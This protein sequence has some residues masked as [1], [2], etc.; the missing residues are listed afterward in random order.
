MDIY[1]YGESINF[2]AD[3]YDCHTGNIFKLQEFKYKVKDDPTARIRV[4]DAEGN[5]IGYANRKGE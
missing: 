1:E 4:T 2:N 5:T 3:Y